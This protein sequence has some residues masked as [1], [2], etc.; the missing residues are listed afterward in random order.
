MTR[1]SPPA[2]CIIVEN[3]PVPYDWRTWQE[4]CALTQAGN[5][6]SVICAKAP[7]YESSR[8]IREGIEIYRHGVWTSSGRLGHIFEY[9]SALI[10]EFCLACLVFARTRFSVLHACN[11]PDIIFLVALP[12]KLLGVRFVFDH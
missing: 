1:R 11:P 4:A 10:A 2:V 5:R 9:T 6:V 3:E 8:E 12:F 7:G